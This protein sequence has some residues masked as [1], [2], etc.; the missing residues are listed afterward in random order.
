MRAADLIPLEK[1]LLVKPVDCI[2][3]EETY[4]VAWE[5]LNIRSGIDTGI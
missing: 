2:A 1:S 5:L 3:R 4:L